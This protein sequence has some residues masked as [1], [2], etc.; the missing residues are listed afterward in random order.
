MCP[1][2]VSRRRFLRRLGG[3][4][5]T[6]AT[7]DAVLAETPTRRPRV[8]FFSRAGAYESEIVRRDRGA[9]SRCERLMVEMGRAV[10][11]EVACEKD[12]RVFDGDLSSFDAFVLFWNF[13]PMKPN[14]AG[15]PPLTTQGKQRMIQAVASGKGVLG[16]HCAAYAFLSGKQ[17][18]SQPRE[19]RDPYVAMLGGEL[20]ACLPKQD[21]RYRIVSPHFPGVDKLGATTITL[22]D[23][24][25]GLKNYADDLHVIA[26]Q[27]TEGLD[28]KAFQRPPFPCVWARCHGQGRVFYVA[29]GHDDDAWRTE[30]FKQ[31]VS[32]G[33]DWTLGRV[34]ADLTPNLKTVCP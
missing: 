2:P 28:N 23:E 17:E 15:E 34:D 11:V 26:V 33:L 16:I 9:L 14:K 20:Q 12:G 8:L 13:D 18:E 4:A 10:G 3:A 30:P 21:T 32:S 29:W 7:V 6:A 22:H 24:P 25:Y 31:I 5:L 19:R 27:E 1:G